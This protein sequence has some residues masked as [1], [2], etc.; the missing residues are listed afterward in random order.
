MRQHPHNPPPLAGEVPPNGGG[1]G[2]LQEPPQNQKSLFE[3]FTVSKTIDKSTGKCY[4]F[5]IG[6]LCHAA[7]YLNMT[8][9]GD[10]L[11]G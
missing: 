2:D 11:Y 8:N 3:H 9:R 5:R 1:G 7:A 10:S 6:V 4:N